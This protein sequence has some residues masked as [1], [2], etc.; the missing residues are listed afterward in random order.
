MWV[1][2]P[3]LQEPAAAS[4][5]VIKY[6]ACVTHLSRRRAR[7][8]RRAGMGCARTV[9]LLGC[10]CSARGLLLPP[11]RAGA[12]HP[13]LRQVNQ[14]RAQPAVAAAVPAEDA[15]DGGG[16]GPTPLLH[17]P[18]PQAVICAAGYLAHVW[19]L[20]R[21]SVHLGGFDVGLDTLAG[22]AVLL[23]AMAWR[24]RNGRAAVPDWLSGDAATEEA[25]ACADI[26][27]EPPKEKLRLLATGVLLMVAPLLFSMLAPMLETMVY[28]LAIF[29]PLTEASLLG[30]RLLVE[31]TL[32]YVAL[33]KL[34]QS[35]HPEFF[36]SRVR[37]R[38][39]RRAATHSGRARRT[40]LPRAR[41]PDRTRARS[42][43]PTANSPFSTRPSVGR[44]HVTPRRS[45]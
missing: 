6:H 1:E 28:V 39:R 14:P 23:A 26:R 34:I 8:A 12:A 27:A 31:Q 43:P 9:L 44:R 18:L 35:R 19:T 30:A 29:F 11:L 32:L 42:G 16:A 2:E 24:A 25:S 17:Q 45:G 4:V 10:A 38:A 40:S 36:S 7:R 3:V 33:C 41:P 21:R 13:A 15:A 20:S 37:T 5:N 22:I